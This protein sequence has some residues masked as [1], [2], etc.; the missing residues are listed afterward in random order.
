MSRV[1]G[2]ANQTPALR[3]TAPLSNTVALKMENATLVVVMDS[4]HNQAV[5]LP[6]T[7]AAPRESANLL[8]VVERNVALPPKAA[9]NAVPM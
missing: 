4:A 9:T 5:T 8:V 1:M 3:S 2:F 7:L 6:L